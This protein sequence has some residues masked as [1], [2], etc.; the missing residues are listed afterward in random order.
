MQIIIDIS[1]SETRTRSG[2]S[3][4]EEILSGIVYGRRFHISKSSWLICTKFVIGF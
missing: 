1:V 2:Q 3:D 4:V